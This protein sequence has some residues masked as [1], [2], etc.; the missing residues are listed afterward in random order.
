MQ[1]QTTTHSVKGIKDTNRYSPQE[2]TFREAGSDKCY[3][4][5]CCTHGD[6]REANHLGY[7][8]NSEDVLQ[9]HSQVGTQDKLEGEARKGGG[10]QKVR[11]MRVLLSLI[12][13]FK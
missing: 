8:A 11:G 7:P 5:C 4:P 6:C 9:V 3:Y 1:S 10:G 12:S 13:R 2:R